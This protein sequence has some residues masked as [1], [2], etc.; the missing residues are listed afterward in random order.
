M[1]CFREQ[2]TRVARCDL[3]IQLRLHAL[4]LSSADL[5]AAGLTIRFLRVSLLKFEQPKSRVWGTDVP[6]RRALVSSTT[7]FKWAWCIVAGPTIDR[8]ILERRVR[9]G[10]NDRISGLDEWPAAW[11]ASCF[12]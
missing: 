11:I 9:L 2:I 6:I 4:F 12:R 1:D 3:Q 10:Q 7:H 8:V 5:L